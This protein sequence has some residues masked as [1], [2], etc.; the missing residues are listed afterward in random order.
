MPMAVLWEQRIGVR[1][2]IDLIVD[3]GIYT[4]A[5]RL[6]LMGRTLHLGHL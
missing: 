1:H 2:A 5:D 6:G 3:T 4:N